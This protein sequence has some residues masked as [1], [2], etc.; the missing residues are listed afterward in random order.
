MENIREAIASA[1]RNFSEAFDRGDAG[2]VA[3]WYSKDA[4]LMPPDSPML[5]GTDAIRDFWQG[6]MNMGVK[7]AQLETLEVEEREDIAYELGRF[8]LTLGSPGG[9]AVKMRG[10]YVVVWKKDDGGGWK[11][12]V[13]IWNGDSPA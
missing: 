5:K 8:E 9:E 10:K 12:H 6:A 11:M 1:V 2:A 4:T 13:D 7:G 3:A